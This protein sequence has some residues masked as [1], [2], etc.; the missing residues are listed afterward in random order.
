ML[1]VYSGGGFIPILLAVD[2]PR[3]RWRLFAHHSSPAVGQREC[4]LLCEAVNFVHGPE[5][6]ELEDPVSRTAEDGF[7]SADCF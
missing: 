1:K 2:C 4:R 3:G 7:V 5:H 6:S